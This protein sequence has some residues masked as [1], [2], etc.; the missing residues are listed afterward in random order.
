MDRLE[1][2]IERLEPSMSVEGQK[3]KV[4]GRA[5]LL[6]EARRLLDEREEIIQAEDQRRVDAW[7]L[8]VGRLIDAMAVQ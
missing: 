3:S 7:R 2:E 1:K 4:E 6:A 8:A 5:A